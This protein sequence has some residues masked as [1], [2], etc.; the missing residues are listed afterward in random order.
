MKINTQKTKVLVC[1][2]NNITIKIHLQNNQEIKQVE[3][4]AYLGSIISKDGR[5]AKEIVKR[6]CQAKIAFNKKR[7]LFTS[8]SISVR[9]R[10]NLLMTY[11]W[12]IML[13]G[14]ETWTIAKTERRRIE[15]F[16]MWCFRRM[17]KIS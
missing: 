5:S 11:V 1:S 9:N 13:Y 15:A 7:G 16:E 12:S 6:I 4:F 14:S 8:K 2:K 3:E 10:I 17:L